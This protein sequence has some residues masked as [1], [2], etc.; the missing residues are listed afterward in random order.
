MSELKVIQY[1]RC[2]TFEK[3][4]SGKPKTKHANSHNSN[5]LSPQHGDEAGQ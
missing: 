3:T 2:Y 1:L 5:T 4:K